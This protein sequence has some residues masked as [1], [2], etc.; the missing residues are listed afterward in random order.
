MI[1]QGMTLQAIQKAYAA[2]FGTQSL[3]VPSQRGGWAR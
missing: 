1:G 2:R 3:A